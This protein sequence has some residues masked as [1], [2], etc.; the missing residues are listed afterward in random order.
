M[1]IYNIKLNSCISP[2]T[3]MS[4]MARFS[5]IHLFSV[6][7][8][9]DTCLIYLAWHLLSL[10][11]EPVNIIQAVTAPSHKGSNTSQALLTW[12][13]LMRCDFPSGLD[14]W[15]N[16]LVSEPGPYQSGKVK[17]WSVMVGGQRGT[18]ARA[19]AGPVV[20]HSLSSSIFCLSVWMEAT[21]NSP[22]V[23]WTA[24]Y[25]VLSE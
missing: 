20:E 13:L 21:V 14:K 3:A 4:L 19:P 17:P 7:G 6:Q 23:S 5:A 18:T 24:Q 10:W 8:D 25:P 1:V 11:G 15:M 2:Q 12:G 22:M 16:L 9:S